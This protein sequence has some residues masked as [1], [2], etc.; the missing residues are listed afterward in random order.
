MSTVEEIENAIS[1]L[2]KE[3]FTRLQ[4]WLDEFQAKVWD[5]EFEED[6]RTG[7][8]DKLAEEAIKEFHAGNCKE[9]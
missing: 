4:K 6:A 2:P 1:K 7:K 5:Q 8:L 3:E 9:L